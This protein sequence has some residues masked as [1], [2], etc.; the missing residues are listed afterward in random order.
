MVGVA[1]GGI[2]I[3]P[4]SSAL[5]AV[6]FGRRTVARLATHLWSR[7]ISTKMVAM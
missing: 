2:T 1:T 7:P 6:S 4:D 5:D 3:D